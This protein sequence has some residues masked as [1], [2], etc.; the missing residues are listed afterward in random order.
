MR[1]GWSQAEILTLITLY[2]EEKTASEISDITNKPINSVK[3]KIQLLRKD[4]TL[5]MLYKTCYVCRLKMS[6]TE[7][8][9]KCGECYQK[10]KENL[11]GKLLLDLDN[12]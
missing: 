2:N 1:H 8:F 6:V 3:Y 7:R 9:N 12:I 4:G 11:T 10:N 5:T